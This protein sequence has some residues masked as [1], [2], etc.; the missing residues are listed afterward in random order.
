M[1]VPAND[2]PLPAVTA[3]PMRSSIPAHVGM[4]DHHDRIGPARHHAA[5]CDRDGG[6][7]L[8]HCR[9]YDGGVDDFVGELDEPRDFFRRAEGVLRNHRIAVDVRSIE[10]RHVNGRCDIR[11]QH[12]T[13]R[14]IQRDR[15]DAARCWIDRRAEPPLGFV[16]IEDLEKLLLLTHRASTV[17]VVT[18]RSVAFTVLVDDDESVGSSC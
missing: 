3:R 14:R 7:T 1:S 15:L 10:R 6:S 2:T 4:L 18:A 17:D 12:S 11:S 8:D 16:A 5:G 13:E 9:G